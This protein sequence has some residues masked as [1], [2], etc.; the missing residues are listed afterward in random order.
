MDSKIYIG[1]IPFARKSLYFSFFASIIALT[2][3]ELFAGKISMKSILQIIQAVNWPELIIDENVSLNGS[4][5]ILLQKE[6]EKYSLFFLKRNVSQTDDVEIVD[7]V[8]VYNSLERVVFPLDFPIDNI[9]TRDLTIQ[10]YGSLDDVFHFNVKRIRVIEITDQTDTFEIK[11]AEHKILFNPNEIQKIIETYSGFYKEGKSYSKKLVTYKSN[12]LQKNYF[13]IDKEK[14]T[15]SSKGEFA[16]LIDRF[17]LSTKRSKTDFKTYLNERDLLALQD[18]S[19]KLIQ[20]EV[21]GADF[22]TQL[23]DYFIKVKLE[24]I[25]KLG[26]EILSLKGPSLT[27]VV[28]KKIVQKIGAA[29]SIKQMES[30]WQKYFENYLSF[31]IF[32]YQKLYPKIELNVDLQKKYPDFIGVN[33]FG[34]VDIIEIKTHLKY[35]VT[36]DLSHDNYAFSSELSKAIIQTINYMDALV[37][38]KIKNKTTKNNL[39]GQILDGNIYRPRGIIIISSYDNLAKGVKPTDRDFEKIKR[40]FTKLRHGLHN[41]Q[42]L[43]FDELL[44]MAENYK[45]NIVQS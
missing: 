2:N 1:S 21:F 9:L 23:N 36:K 5:K 20:K 34:G 32:S 28:A 17:N 42:I 13:G 24:E 4:D 10:H 14:K 35:V 7:F 37:Q 33:H 25:I 26:R 22:L 11:E 12:E 29:N 40:D 15:L 3:D 44:N 31:L 19:L 16:F 41:I 8:N 45:D 39:K 30:L 6:D 27:T 18:L 38:E 43:T